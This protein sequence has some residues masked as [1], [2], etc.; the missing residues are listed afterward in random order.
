M[1]ST[2]DKYVA[3]LVVMRLHAWVLKACRYVV[4]GKTTAYCQLFLPGFDPY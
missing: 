2:T 1:W 4:V 3:S